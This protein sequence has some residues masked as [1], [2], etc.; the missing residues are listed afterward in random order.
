MNQAYKHQKLIILYTLDSNFYDWAGQELRE[1]AQIHKHAL[2]DASSL[3]RLPWDAEQGPTE[4]MIV[5]LKCHVSNL[6]EI[7]R[8]LNCQPSA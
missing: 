3:E 2:V 4:D 1:I 7:L 8:N 5:R 6:V